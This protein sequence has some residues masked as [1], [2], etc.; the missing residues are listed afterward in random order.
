M[1]PKTWRRVTRDTGQRRAR[2]SNYPIRKRSGTF[3]ASAPKT[4][5]RGHTL[6]FQITIFCWRKVKTDDKESSPGHLQMNFPVQSAGILIIKGFIKQVNKKW[7]CF[8][9]RIK[10]L[11]LPMQLRHLWPNISCFIY[12]FS[13]AE[14]VKKTRKQYIAYWDVPKNCLSFKR[15]K[16]AAQ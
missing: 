15:D 8:L 14:G 10:S 6:I 5:P 3:P 12:N 2:L 9:M 11:Y 7:N 1:R 4:A 13:G 16:D